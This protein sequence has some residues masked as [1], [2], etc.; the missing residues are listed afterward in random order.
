MTSNLECGNIL[1]Q[2]QS[3]G[4]AHQPTPETALNIEA[5]NATI[6]SSGDGFGDVSFQTWDD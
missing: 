3:F 2:L 4:D 1:G 5:T 6:A